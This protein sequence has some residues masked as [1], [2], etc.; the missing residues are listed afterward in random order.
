MI[1]WCVANVIESFACHGD[2][3]WLA[4]FKRMSGFD[5]ERKL[6]FRPAKHN[7]PNLTPLWANWNLGADSSRAAAVGILSAR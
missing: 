4:N 2:D 5:V 1:R 6:L 3:V 7:L